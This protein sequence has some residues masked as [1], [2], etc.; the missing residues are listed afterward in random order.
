MKQVLI[1]AN[2]F[3][4]CKGAGN[5]TGMPESVSIYGKKIAISNGAVYAT[6]EGVDNVKPSDVKVYFSGNSTPQNV[7]MQER[8]VLLKKSEQVSFK[9]ENEDAS[10]LKFNITVHVT[11]LDNESHHNGDLCI[12]IPLNSSDKNE[13]KEALPDEMNPLRYVFEIPYNKE[14]ADLSQI[15]VLY[16]KEPESRLKSTDLRFV[17]T[18]NGNDPLLLYETFATQGKEIS[19]PLYIDTSEG[20]KVYELVIK[21]LVAQ[22][23]QNANIKKV[24]FDGMQ[25]IIEGKNIR[26]DS[27]FAVSSSVQV[28]VEMEVNGASCVI[29]NGESVTIKE[30]GAVFSIVASPKSIDGIRKTYNVVLEAPANMAI[31]KVASL[32][33]DKNATNVP[34]LN[35]LEDRGEVLESEGKR[36]ITLPLYTAA[37][38]V[39]IH[40]EVEGSLEIANVYFLKKGLWKRLD[41][42]SS[43]RKILTLREGVLPL[44]PSLSNELKLKV[45]FRN[46]SYDLITIKFKKN[47]TLAPI[48]LTAL[49]L[50]D[51]E[52]GEADIIS[53][54]NDSNPTFEAKGPYLYVDIVSKE[55]LH[56]KIGDAVYKSVY[57]G[58]FS[59]GLSLPIKMPNIGEESQ[60]QIDIE[61]DYAQT[62]KLKFKVRR[63]A[64]AVDLTLY[65]SINAQ[66]VGKDLLDQFKGTS[67]PI[68]SI[69]GAVMLFSIDVMEDIINT[70]TLNEEA[71]S[72]KTLTD[73]NTGRQFYRY[74]AKIESLNVGDVTPVK[75]E[76]VPKNAEDYN[77]LL[78]KFKVKREK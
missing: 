9:I 61:C 51:S 70:A 58:F 23:D 40:F 42:Y 35:M 15:W 31:K 65:P 46:N 72:K 77:N 59:Y 22:E 10:P 49:Y 12:W 37:E 43:T 67:E 29:N 38:D 11:L 66:S 17:T 26:C 2:I 50:N 55:A 32:N 74:E 53:Y 48:T 1:F 7:K 44:P 8:F 27:T 16:K 71:F 4:S 64:G 34:T 52:I 63:L 47:E 69:S 28:S 20:P 54:F 30:D 68:V 18:A 45:V 56:A 5:T 36:Y 57:S 76:I 13:A 62:A 14:D 73:S 3:Q 24:T 33:Y 60:I 6:L 25:G 78:W 75:I 41:S 19:V 39:A 21:T